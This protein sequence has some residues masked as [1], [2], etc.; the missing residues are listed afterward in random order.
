[1]SSQAVFSG[2][3]AGA[4]AFVALKK[5]VDTVDTVLVG[6]PRWTRAAM[7]LTVSAFLAAAFFLLATRY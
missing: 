6:G 7:G 1:M 3:A 4:F 2:I 5:A